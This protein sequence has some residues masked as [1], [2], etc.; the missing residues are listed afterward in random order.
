MSGQEII[1]CK[2]CGSNR[3]T[4][5]PVIA[6]LFLSAGCFVWIP[7]IGWIGAPILLLAAIVL[8]VLPTGKRFVRCEDCKHS[9]DVDKSKY[10]EF[11]E[12]IK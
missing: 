8:M 6:I 5:I 2:K 12:A 10:K 1:K 11:K 7:V 3:I 9:F 4:G